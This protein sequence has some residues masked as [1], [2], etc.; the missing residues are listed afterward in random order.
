MNAK[1]FMLFSPEVKGL[2]VSI[3]Q[4]AVDGQWLVVL[5]YDIEKPPFVLHIVSHPRLAEAFMQAADMLR[6]P[7]TYVSYIS[8]DSLT[9]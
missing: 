7:S 1:T 6:N 9:N 4:S 3:R 2:S 8:F 5:L